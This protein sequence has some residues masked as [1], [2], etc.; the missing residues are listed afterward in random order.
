VTCSP[1]PVYIG[2]CTTGGI[3]HPMLLLRRRMFGMTML[4]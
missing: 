2:S 1:K 4:K 3:R